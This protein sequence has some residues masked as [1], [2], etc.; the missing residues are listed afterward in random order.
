MIRHCMGLTALA[1]L[2]AAPNAGAQRAR[3]NSS[4]RSITWSAGAG[5]SV[6]TGDLSNGAASGF[7]VQ[8]TS[9]YHRLGWP[10]DVRAEVAYHRFGEK[11]FT[12]AGARP[13][14][15][16][17]YTGRSSSIAGVVDASYA[18]NS[19]GRM[20]P[21]LLGG[22]GVYNTRAELTRTGSPSTTSSET[23]VGLNVGGGMNFSLLGRRTYLEA[24]YH[25]VDQAAWVPITFGIRF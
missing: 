18:L 10:I 6:P 1:L 4:S 21:Y 25:K 12:V 8:G 19:I 14:Q 3:A 20:K 16:I 15:T 11:D 5:M 22:P 13:G 17:A 2:I 24:R 7:H 9:G 23:K